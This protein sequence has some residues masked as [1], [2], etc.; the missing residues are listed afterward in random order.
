[1]LNNILWSNLG[2]LRQRLG[3]CLGWIALLFAVIGLLLIA[4]GLGHPAQ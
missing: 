1:M 2:P 4:N 3:G